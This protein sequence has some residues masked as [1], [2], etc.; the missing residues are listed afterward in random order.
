MRRLPVRIRFAYFKQQRTKVGMT[1]SDAQSYV[2]LEDFSGL[3]DGNKVDRGAT[4]WSRAVCAC[5]SRVCDACNLH[6]L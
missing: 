4:A 5:D 6:I 1:E 2:L 3:T